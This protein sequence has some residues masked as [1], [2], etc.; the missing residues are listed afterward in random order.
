MREIGEQ[1]ELL[2][3]EESKITNSRKYRYRASSFSFSREVLAHLRRYPLDAADRKSVTGEDC[4]HKARVAAKRLDLSDV[5]KRKDERQKRAAVV[6]VNKYG[7]ESVPGF[8]GVLQ[9]QRIYGLCRVDYFQRA[10]RYPL[11]A[12][13]RTD[14]HN[15]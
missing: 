1:V 15:M 7:R 11:D 5:G 3:R 14:Y 9:H 4:Q 10:R 6:V 8:R 2:A 13:S 12:P